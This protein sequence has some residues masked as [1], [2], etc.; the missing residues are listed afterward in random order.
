MVP[1]LTTE[2]GAIEVAE[3]IRSGALSPIAATEAAIARIEA[4]D[5]PINAVVI[6]DF[7]RARET[8]RGMT[9][10]GPHP[11]GRAGRP[12]PARPRGRRCRGTP[13][14]CW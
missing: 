7:E 2:P 4:L 3:Q 6:R 5:G 11:N 12:R 13:G 1:K 14:L 8:A 9:A 10:P